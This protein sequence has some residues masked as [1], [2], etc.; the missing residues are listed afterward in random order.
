MIR[1]LD[2]V[3]VGLIEASSFSALV[4]K[5]KTPT[6]GSRRV[7]FNAGYVETPVVAYAAHRG[8]ALSS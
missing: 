7:P 8:Q 3:I 2:I 5:D 1:C 6:V 4:R